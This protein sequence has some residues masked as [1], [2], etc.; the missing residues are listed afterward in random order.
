[1]EDKVIQIVSA[2]LSIASDNL[3]DGSGPSDVEVW[4][5]LAHMRIISALEEEFKVSFETDE[6]IAMENVKSIRDVLSRK[7][8]VC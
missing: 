2:T 1:M 8:C 5:S 6:I 7:G 4:D 3:H